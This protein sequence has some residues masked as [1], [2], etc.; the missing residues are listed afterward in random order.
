MKKLKQ[1]KVLLFAAGIILA[2]TAALVISIHVAFG[3]EDSKVAVDGLPTPV[4]GGTGTGATPEVGAQYI[5]EEEAKTEFN[6]VA[7]NLF[8]QT[9]DDAALT[10]EFDGN[11]V[12]AQWIVKSNALSCTI[13][14]LSSEVLSCECISG[15]AGDRINQSEYHNRVHDS[16]TF[17]TGDCAADMYNSPDN[18]YIKAALAVANESLT[19]GRTVETIKISGGVFMWD[20][21]TAT[22]S[23][24]ADVDILMTTGRSYRLVF[25]GADQ[26]VLAAY[27]SYPNQEACDLGYFYEEEVPDSFNDK[28]QTDWPE[29]TPTVMPGE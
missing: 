10:A 11:G 13:D 18:V 2:C 6:W 21:S 16:L 1:G 26:I 7:T 4:A 3:A 9:V 23:V 28:W 5:T 25:W 12:H 20:S 19:D 14:A 22:A 8:D 17:T 24:E 27:Y 15:Y 29:P